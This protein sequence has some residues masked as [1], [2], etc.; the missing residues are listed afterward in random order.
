MRNMKKMCCDVGTLLT[1]AVV[2]GGGARREVADQRVDY[3]PVQFSL[4]QQAAFPT[5]LPLH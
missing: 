5:H 1:H 4:L 3:E 2:V